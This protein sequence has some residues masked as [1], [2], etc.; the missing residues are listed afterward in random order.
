[1][2]GQDVN[3]HS[4]SHHQIT[5]LFP[6]YIHGFQIHS[7]TFQVL[8]TDLNLPPTLI[9]LGCESRTFE[10]GQQI[11]QLVISIWPWVIQNDLV[12]IQSSD[13]DAF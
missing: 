8:E 12:Q 13:F 7:I 5:F 9:K 6:F 3:E 4:Y 2:D 10:V 11:D 1:M